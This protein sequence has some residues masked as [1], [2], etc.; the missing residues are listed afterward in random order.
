MSP[1]SFENKVIFNLYIYIYINMIWHWIITKGWY[2]INQIIKTVF[3]L[4]QSAG[5]TEYT[6][7][8][9]TEE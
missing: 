1:N 5:A 3:H 4:A 6:D 2:A 9:S 7:C 8:F